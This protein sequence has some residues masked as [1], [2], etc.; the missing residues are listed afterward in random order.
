MNYGAMGS[1]IGHELTHGFDDQGSKFDAEGNRKNW[2][3]PEDLKNFQARGECIV[4]QFDGFE[5]EAGL[6]E[7]G[8]LVEGESIADLGGLTIAYA[9]LQKT[10]E[11]KSAPAAIDGFTPEQRFFLGWATVWEGNTRPEFARLMTQTDPHPLD[12]FRVNGPLSNMPEFAKA[13]GC[14]ADS[15][16]VRAPGVRCRIW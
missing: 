11:G 7:N 9:A 5:V 2:W 15:T 6:H 10:F 12:Q 3:T 8:K 13:Y 14:A 16:M 4:K 1:V